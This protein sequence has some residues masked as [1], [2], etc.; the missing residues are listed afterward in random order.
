[1]HCVVPSR[2]YYGSAAMSRSDTGLVPRPGN[3]GLS[4]VIPCKSWETMGV[5]MSSRKMSPCAA[6]GAAYGL[7]RRRGGGMLLGPA[8][9][10]CDA[11]CRNRLAAVPRSLILFNCRSAVPVLCAS[12]S[13]SRYPGCLRMLVCQG[14][15]CA[16][17][18]V[19]ATRERCQ[20]DRRQAAHEAGRLQSAAAK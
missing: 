6:D 19:W 11:D 1:M 16:D 12:Q 5:P 15:L 13:L 3:T 20:G 2:S 8:V 7:S 18:P 4:V 9:Q 10:R 17:P 14:S